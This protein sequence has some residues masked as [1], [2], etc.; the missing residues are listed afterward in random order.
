MS[1]NKQ[2]E[3]PKQ[4]QMSKSEQMGLG[5]REGIIGQYK[6][7]VHLIEKDIEDFLNNTIKPRLGLKPDDVV[8][9][10]VDAGIIQV[11]PKPKIETKEEVKVDERPTN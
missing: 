1:K 3:K 5:G 4:F 10:D 2:P 8:R 6:F 11:M 9:Y 7:M